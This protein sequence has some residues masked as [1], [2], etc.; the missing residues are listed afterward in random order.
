MLSPRLSTLA[1]RRLLLLSSPPS[2][3]LS[4]MSRLGSHVSRRAASSPD[5]MRYMESMANG[6]PA[7]AHAQLM[8]LEALLE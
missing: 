5:A 7:N 8:Y 1:A 6:S 2:R 3:S 4:F